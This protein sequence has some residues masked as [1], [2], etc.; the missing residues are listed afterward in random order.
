[1]ASRSAPVPNRL[2]GKVALVTGASSGIGRACADRFIAEGADVVA[3][4]IDESGLARLADDHGDRVVTVPCDVTSEPDVERLFS[5]GVER[6]GGVDVVVAN[7]GK[8]TYSL[9]ADHE[10]DAWK[11]IIDLCLT[12]VFLTLKH[13]SRS[14]R[15][16][17]SVITVASLNAIQ[18]AEGMAAYCAAKAGAAHLSRVAAMELGHRGIRVNTVAPGLVETN[19]T[20]GMWMVPGIVEEFVDNS[21]L[22][23]F[24]HP[25]EIAAVVAFLASDDAGFM[26]SS[27]LSIDGGGNTGRY[28]DLPG[29]FRR[30]TGG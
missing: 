16:N 12:G 5:V 21:S 24:A 27:F 29:A 1:M 18:P 3:G 28:P 11:E 8:G 20:A 19:A 7:A 26:S 25:S 15:D 14:M 13:A 9:L 6:L 10:L 2:Q 4:D 22:G 23:R 17:G 30:F